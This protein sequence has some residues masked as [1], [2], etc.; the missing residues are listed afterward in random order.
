[1]STAIVKQ[2]LE[3]GG[4]PGKKDL[5][6]ALL[7]EFGGPAALASEIYRQYTKAKKNPSAAARMLADV[8]T[9]IGQAATK[10]TASDIGNMSDEEIEATMQDAFNRGILKPPPG[11]ADA[12]PPSAGT[13]PAS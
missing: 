13:A 3:A 8:L 2:L 7:K 11:V 10:S 1:V 12:T 9:L 6:E 4:L 5:A